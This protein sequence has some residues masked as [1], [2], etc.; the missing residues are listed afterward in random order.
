MATAPI[1]I[2]LASKEDKSA[3][4]E[5]A[6]Y[7]GGMASFVQNAPS[8]IAAYV[9]RSAM[10]YLKNPVDF[11][12]EFLSGLTVTILQV[13][14]SVAFSYVAGVDPISGLYSTFLLGFITAAVGGKE[15]MIS[16]AAG[17][18]AVVAKDLMAADGPLGSL[19]REQRFTHLLFTMFLC[20]IIQMLAGI[21]QLARLVRLIPQS[22]MLGFM[23]GLAV[24]I[25]MAQFTA[26]QYCPISPLFQDCTEAERK[27]LPIDE[28]R[29]WMML[30]LVFMTMF[31]MWGFPKLPKV[32]KMLPAS[33]VN[34]P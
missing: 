30:A 21:F 20:G 14:E 28:L 18:M 15:A 23:N 5:C 13:P 29:T 22:A 31:I 10:F 7:C 4:Q 9:K 6:D 2:E 24:V 33:L 1:A 34:F 32:G 17:A 11:K 19:T 8:Q 16:G 12:N 26:F 3:I 27:W 25:F